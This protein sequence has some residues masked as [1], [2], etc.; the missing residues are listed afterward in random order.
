MEYVVRHTPAQNALIDFSRTLWFFVLTLEIFNFFERFHIQLFQMSF[1]NNLLVE[2]GNADL[3]VP[4]TSVNYV[5]G[6]SSASAVSSAIRRIDNLAADLACISENALT[7]RALERRK[8][9]LL[10]LEFCMGDGLAAASDLPLRGEGS[11]RLL[12]KLI[13]SFAKGCL[14]GGLVDK[15]MNWIAA[16]LR[17]GSVRVAMAR[18]ALHEVHQDLVEKRLDL[19]LEA[20][21]AGDTSPSVLGDWSMRVAHASTI[22][23]PGFSDSDSD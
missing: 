5:Q 13:L 1:L 22:F 16:A 11:E 15:G 2:L 6:A 9:Y 19:C 12:E 10:E 14:F 23:D 21:A 7:D 18:D 17:A 3:D 20:I 8:E 4:E